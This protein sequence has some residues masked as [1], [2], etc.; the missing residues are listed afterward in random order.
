[1]SKNVQP[2]KHFGTV[3]LC[4]LLLGG[5]FLGGRFFNSKEGS[6][7]KVD[8]AQEQDAHE[9]AR[10]FKAFTPFPTATSVRLY[11]HKDAIGIEDGIIPKG[12]FPKGGAL[13]TAEE[14]DIVH[15]SFKWSTPPMMVAACC[16]PRHA[17]T[18]YDSGNRY[19][20]SIS[21]CYECS[22]A[23]VDG[24]AAPKDLE[25]VEWDAEA[26]AKVIH[27]HGIKTES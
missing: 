7:S 25:W 26:L 17:F 13:L 1:M 4:L 12:S 14:V 23:N 18:F 10:K 20:G 8:W 3:L 6:S 21:V 2:S 19:L 5:V 24:I 16:I 22:C 27:A 11:A 9:K 15:A